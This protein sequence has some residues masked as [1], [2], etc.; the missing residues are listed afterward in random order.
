MDLFNDFTYDLNN[1]DRS[2]QFEQQDKRFYSGIRASHTWDTM[3]FGRESTTTL[4]FQ[5]RN[6][7]IRNGLYDTQDRIRYATVETANVLET[8]LGI[9]LE[10]RAQW[11]PKFR[12]EASLRGDYYNFNVHS[13]IPQNSGTANAGIVSPKLNLIF[14][15]WRGTEFYISGGYGFHS[16][17]ARGITSN[18]SPGSLLPAQRVTPLVRAK[19]G[20]VG[21]R[22]GIIPGLTSTAS[23]WILD[24]DS[25]LVFDGD[26][27]ESVPSRPSRRYGVELSNFYTPT[28]W[29]TIDADH[30]I[31]RA[32]FRESAPIGNDVP[33]SI[34]DV[35]T[36]GFTLHDLVPLKDFFGGMRLRY[37]GPR[38]LVED[39]SIRSNSSTLVDAQ[40]GY[41]LTPSVTLKLDFLNLFNV[42]T[43]DIQ[44]YYVSRL[45]GEPAAGV[46]DRHVH[47][48]EP[49]E[50]RA[51]LIYRF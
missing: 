27:A 47:P 30:S 39:G 18:L 10:N 8:S 7:D 25:E 36:A 15:P 26:T 32:R 3:L 34:E 6:D 9:Y 16:N 46:A 45:P 37:F 29:L 50:V 42:K 4:G 38:P 44:Y 31:S 23:L 17:D 22:T 11:L 35:L 13:N 20:E 5:G 40:V 51:S 2:D 19:G 12:T 28:N 48:A 33:E 21:T 49:F 43:D 24:L 1:P 41:N 14:G